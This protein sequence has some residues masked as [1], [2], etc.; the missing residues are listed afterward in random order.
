[1]RAQPM[2]CVADVVQSSLWFQR[3]LGF[4]SAHGG[5]EYERLVSEGQL[6]LQLHAWDVHDHAHMGKPADPVGSGVVLWFE[7][8]HV[9]RDY[10]RALAASAIVL[11]P[12]H[13]NPLAQH[14]EFW[15]QEPN[16]YVVVVAGPHGQLGA[17]GAGAD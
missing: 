12:I 3:V 6:V 8:E 5:P 10:E 14:L 11:E 17:L 4:S 1:M 16:G 9:E 7:S 15:L 2:V 13:V